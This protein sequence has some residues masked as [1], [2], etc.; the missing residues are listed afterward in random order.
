[1][2]PGEAVLAGQAVLTVAELGHLQVETT[3]LSERDVA[4]VAAGQPVT[5]FVEA[6]GQELRGRVTQI[7][8]QATVVG[9]DSV[10]AVTVELD[11]QPL[12]LRWGMSAEVD[13]ATTGR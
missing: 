2:N 6:L 12:G 1:V 7:A 4:R 5:V 13:I 10:Y 11:D 9:G 8:L 3:D